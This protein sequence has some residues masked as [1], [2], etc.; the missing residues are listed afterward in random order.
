MN[1]SYPMMIW[2]LVML[3]LGFATPEALPH[4]MPSF[5]QQFAEIRAE[6]TNETVLTVIEDDVVTDAEAELL[7]DGYLSCLAEAGFPDVIAEADELMPFTWRYIIDL[8]DAPTAGTPI[9]VDELMREYDEA[10]NRCASE[11]QRALAVRDAMLI[12]PENEDIFVL[13]LEC[14]HK[15]GLVPA[16][17]G[18]EDIEH[19]AMTGDWGPTVQPNTLEFTRCL[20]NPLEVG[21]DP[22]PIPDATPEG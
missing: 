5:E 2:M 1:L 12:N 11:W 10:S 22:M 18:Y 19:A 16:D 6:S 3:T 14:L 9:P 7:R 21:L 20:V 8:R 17:F 15:Y 13:N 4:V